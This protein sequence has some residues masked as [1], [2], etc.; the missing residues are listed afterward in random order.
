MFCTILI[1]LMLNILV[2]QLCLLYTYVISITV[3]IID[4]LLIAHN[5]LRILYIHYLF[6]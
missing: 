4:K 6:F 3:F 1:F 5:F 2:F